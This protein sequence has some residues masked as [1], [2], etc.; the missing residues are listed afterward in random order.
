[1]RTMNELEALAET[2]AERLGDYDR[3][4]RPAEFPT[5]R[6]EAAQAGMYSWWADSDAVA[7]L[8]D[9]LGAPV[10]RLVYAGQAGASSTRTAKPSRATLLSRVRG[11]HIRGNIYGSTMRRTFASVLRE[12]LGLVV[13]S[14]TRLAGDSEARLRAWIEQHLRVAIAAVDDP[15]S[16]ARVEP[17]VLTRLD[18]PLNLDHVTAT[19]LRKRLRALRTGL[20][21]ELSTGAD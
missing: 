10:A 4:V 9:V 3:S 12:P 14:P 21:R 7:T 17:I 18:P 5:D 15:A 13:A 20:S 11:Q 8:A 19:D 6:H 16:L 2:I 1:M